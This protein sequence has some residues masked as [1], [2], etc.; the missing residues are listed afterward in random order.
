MRAVVPTL[1]ASLLCS[2]GAEPPELA[3][4]RLG[5]RWG[6]VARALPCRRGGSP[7]IQDSQLTS[8][9]V[10]RCFLSDSTILYFNQDDLVQIEAL[11]EFRAASPPLAHPVETHW[12]TLSQELTRQF[13][14]NPDSVW[15][16][17]VGDTGTILR[18]AWRPKKSASWRAF[19]ELRPLLRSDSTPRVVGSRGAVRLYRAN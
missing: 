2:C 10:R 4:H 11:T 18:A 14:R 16:T 12:R 8:G 9:L 5:S 7:T 1:T 19:L 6:D 15:L 3:D 17:G 13:R